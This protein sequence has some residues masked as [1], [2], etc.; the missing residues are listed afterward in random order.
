VPG[1]TLPLAHEEDPTVNGLFGMA[2]FV[3]VRADG[4]VA[5]SFKRVPTEQ[6]LTKSLAA[7]R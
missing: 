2:S 6:E 7:L 5:S 3:F 1:L 4:T